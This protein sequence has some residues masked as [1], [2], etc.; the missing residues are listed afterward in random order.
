MS[1][2]KEAPKKKNMMPVIIAVVLVLGGG[3]FFMMGGKKEEKA[4]PEIA[5]GHYPEEVGEFLVNLKGGGYLSTKITV[6]CAEGTTVSSA[7][8]GHGKGGAILPFVNDTVISILTSK[9]MEEIST[10]EGKAKL[11]RELAYHINHASHD[12]VHAK[13]E[14]APKK[15]KKKKRSSG[16]DHGT[17]EELAADFEPEYPE[18]DNDEGP[19][20]KVF[21]LTFTTQS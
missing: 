14:E 15:S 19:V 1:D 12:F 2:A 9:T 11:R 5:L 18:W 10:I 4:V 21:F 7:G 13:G 17:P 20:L 16:D 8:D 6:Q 3:G